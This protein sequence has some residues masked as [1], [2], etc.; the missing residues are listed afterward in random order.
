MLV[1]MSLFAQISSV[2]LEHVK[3]RISRL[4]EDFS[5]VGSYYYISCRQDI[6]TIFWACNQQRFYQWYKISVND[7]HIDDFY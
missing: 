4:V 5:G 3:K 6:E 2:E 1:S 7:N